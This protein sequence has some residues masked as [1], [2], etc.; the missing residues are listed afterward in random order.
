MS[1]YG[2]I[3]GVIKYNLADYGGTTMN[4][5]TNKLKQK[6]ILSNASLLADAVLTEVEHYQRTK[7]EK[8]KI[9]TLDIASAAIPK[10]HA[11]LSFKPTHETRHV[12]YLMSYGTVN[13]L[14]IVKDDKNGE[15]NKDKEDRKDEKEMKIHFYEEN[16]SKESSKEELAITIAK[17]VESYKD[18]IVAF[19]KNTMAY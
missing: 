6:W 12:E 14:N 18:I 10:E 9:I 7:H 8:I 1:V 16:M 5:T 13:S 19:L 11:I 17:D 15:D 3:K 2:I 4:K